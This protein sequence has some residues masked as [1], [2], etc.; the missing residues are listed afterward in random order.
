MAH[1]T[2]N[3]LLVGERPCTVDLGFGWLFAAY[4]NGHGDG[5]CVLGYNDVTLATTFGDVATNVGFKVPSSPFNTFTY[6][7]EIDIAHWWS[8]HSKGANFLM[9][10]GTVHFMTYDASSIIG[11]ISTIN[12]REMFK[13][14]K[15]W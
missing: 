3:T 13:F 7:T 15:G 14:P 1:P 11:P 6:P 9:A 5:D 2:S 10:D 8:F 12:G 4:G